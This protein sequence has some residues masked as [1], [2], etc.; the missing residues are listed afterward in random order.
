MKVFCINEKETSP[1]Y[2]ALQ[3]SIGLFDQEPEEKML[4]PV[5]TFEDA[6]LVFVIGS[7]SL[8]NK[9]YSKDKIFV[10][11]LF[12]KWDIEQ[13][14]NQENPENVLLGGLNLIENVEMLK[15]AHGLVSAQR[16]M[17]CQIEEPKPQVDLPTNLVVTKGSYKVLVIDDTQENLE[18][19]T[20][21]L[22]NKHSVVVANGFEE[23][24]KML[25][26]GSYDC[27][28]SDMQMPDNKHYGSFNM[29]VAKIGGTNPWGWFV[30]FEATSRGLPVAV[31]TDANHHNDWVSA[32][33]DHLKKAEVNGQK[34][35]FFNHIGKRWDTALKMLLEPDSV[36][37]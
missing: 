29:N 19:A 9:H 3:A 26:E 33:F 2:L 8:L 27:V 1:V 12:S 31:V 13:Y 34:V 22:Q 14:N 10:L 11:F 21:L 32:G 7:R 17:A 37:E 35:L 6:E 18:L 20:M 15:V 36:Q 23:G 24:M 4:E 16:G 5:E 28:L 25:Q 30:V